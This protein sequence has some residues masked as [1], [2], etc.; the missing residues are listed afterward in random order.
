MPQP[1]GPATEKDRLAL[2]ANRAEVAMQA[3]RTGFPGMARH[4]LQRALEALDG[5]A[6]TSTEHAECE[7]CG[8][9]GRISTDIPC[10]SCERGRQLAM[11][12]AST[13]GVTAVAT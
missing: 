1:I 3:C 5:I 2:A 10:V 8:G 12:G 4:M 13:P 6:E 7:T 9:T 11:A